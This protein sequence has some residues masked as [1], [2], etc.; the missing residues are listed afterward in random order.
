MNDGT[1][2]TFR[3]NKLLTTTTFFIGFTG[4]P[5]PD[6]LVP[7]TTYY[8]RVDELNDANPDSPWVGD[9]WSFTVPPKIAW[10]PNPPNGGKFVDT[11]AEFSWS[12]GWGAKLHTV[13][14]GDNFDDVNNAT[15]GTAQAGTTYTLDTLEPEKIYYWRVDEFDALATHKGDVWSFTTTGAGAA[16]RASTSTTTT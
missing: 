8:W 13:Y 6:G 16:S 14:F 12:P 11:N 2:D 4:N 15:G 1:G 5:Y 3:D 9:L 7:G 10:K